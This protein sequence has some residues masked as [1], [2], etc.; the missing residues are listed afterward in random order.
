MKIYNYKGLRINNLNTPPY[1]HLLLVLYWPIY[2]LGFALL[3]TFIREEYVNIFY[4]SH[5]LDAHFA[6]NEWYYIPY[7]LWY[8]M[9]FGNVF[10]TMAFD[11][12]TLKK[13]MW[14]V[15]IAYSATL[16]T[17]AVF[18]NGQNF[19]PETFPRENILTSWVQEIYNHDT[20]TNVCPSLHV[21]GAMGVMFSTWHSKYF[22]KWYWKIF[23][24][25]LTYYVSMS[26]VY[27]KQ[28]SIIDVWVG[29]ALSIVVYLV[30]WHTK[31]FKRIEDPNYITPCFKRR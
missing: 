17:Y 29:A 28:H 2:G 14:F 8:V 27:M 1:K 31:P 6:F 19:R 11:I 18:P 20:N 13:Y 26:T 24:I 3:E 15:I 22:S 9:V 21:I 4:I 12:P 7:F 16:I 23:F 10:F 25:V 30:V 5:P